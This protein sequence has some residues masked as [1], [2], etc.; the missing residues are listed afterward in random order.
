[1]ARSQRRTALFYYAPLFTPE[2][3]AFLKSM[4]LFFDDI[5]VFSTP[6]HR[7]GRSAI[8]SYLSAPLGARE[9][10]PRSTV[11]AVATFG[12][13]GQAGGGLPPGPPEVV[14]VRQLEDGPLH[15]TQEAVKALVVPRAGHWSLTWSVM[16]SVKSLD[17]TP[18][19]CSQKR[20]QSC[21]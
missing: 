19:G 21:G 5:A 8:V 6:Q 9:N 3:V 11:G 17:S 1:M 20:P 4:L 2:D 15:G 7:A 12:G 16:S 13:D 14:F 10:V 18:R